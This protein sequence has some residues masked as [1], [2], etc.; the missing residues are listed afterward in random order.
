MEHTRN[1]LRAS[2][3]AQQNHRRRQPPLPPAPS[4]RQLQQ[5]GGYYRR[6]ALGF[7]PP[8][9][10]D[11]EDEYISFNNLP[12]RGVFGQEATVTFGEE[13]TLPSPYAYPLYLHVDLPPIQPV[14]Q[15]VPFNLDFDG[16]E[17]NSY[18]LPKSSDGRTFVVVTDCPPLLQ[19]DEECPVCFHDLHVRRFAECTQC[20]K[21]VCESCIRIL[22]DQAISPSCPLC[23]TPWQTFQLYTSPSFIAPEA[24]LA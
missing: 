4:P 10:G 11:E 8:S 15:T 7:T 1:R 5:Y 24:S 16:D 18:V 20:H 2:L 3:R 21:H 6:H 12:G 13:V 9:R 22:C 14:A 19:A 23:R 17:F